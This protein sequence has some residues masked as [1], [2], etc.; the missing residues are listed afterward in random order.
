[1]NR[2]IFIKIISLLFL[3][4]LTLSCRGTT[5]EDDAPV[6]TDWTHSV[7]FSTSPDTALWHTANGWSNEGMFNCGWKS[8]H[9]LYQNNLMKLKMDNT[10]SSGMPYT[11]GEFRSNNTYGYGYYEVKMK[12]CKKSGTNSSFFLYTGNPWDEIDIEFLG[13]DTTKVQFNYFVNGQGGHEYLY[14]LGFDASK[15]F[16]VYAIEYKK[17]QINW[18]VDGHLAYSVSQSSGLPSHNMQVMANFWPGIGVDYWL[19]PFS[20]SGPLYAEYDYIRFKEY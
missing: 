4:L 17:K 1:M 8:D 12:P 9:V 2:T 7:D 18:Y 10:F 5:E 6:I 13:K 11:S 14:N 19:G 20:Y 3:T 15:A 16:H